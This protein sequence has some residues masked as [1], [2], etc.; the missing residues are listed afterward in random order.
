MMLFRSSSC[1]QVSAFTSSHKYAMETHADKKKKALER[2]SSTPL[3]EQLS[4]PHRRTKSITNSTKLRKRQW[5]RVRAPLVVR[6]LTKIDI[7]I[8]IAISLSK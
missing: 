8:F 2:R 6:Y 5:I 1:K 7:I 3:K 4:F